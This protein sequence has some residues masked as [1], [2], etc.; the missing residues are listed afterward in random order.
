MPEPVHVVV[1]LQV[2]RESISGSAESASG[3]PASFDGWLGLISII[4]RIQANLGG[5]EATGANAPE[6]PPDDQDRHTNLEGD[7]ER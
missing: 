2:D 3:E 7:H 1:D 4:E 6:L 5:H